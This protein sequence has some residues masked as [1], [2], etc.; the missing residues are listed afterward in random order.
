MPMELFECEAAVDRALTQRRPKLVV[1][2]INEVR[3]L[4]TRPGVCFPSPD[5]P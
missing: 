2:I 5:A 3:G 4:S 1:D